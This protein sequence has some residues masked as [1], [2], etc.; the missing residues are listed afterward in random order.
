M[1]GFWARG[2]TINYVA[3]IYDFITWYRL[4][5]IMQSQFR[6]EDIRKRFFQKY[7]VS[8]VSFSG[9]IIVGIIYA[10]LFLIVGK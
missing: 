2:S 10:F 7:T 5:I 6:C 8:H 3:I 1:S 9:D 4:V